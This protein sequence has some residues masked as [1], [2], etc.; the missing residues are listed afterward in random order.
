MP[1]PVNK[2]FRKT[3]REETVPLRS[4]EAISSYLSSF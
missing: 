2:M 1:N 3:A 4:K